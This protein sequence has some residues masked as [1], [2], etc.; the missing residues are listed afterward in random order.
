MEDI[1][2][3]GKAVLIVAGAALS[4]LCFLSAGYDMGYDSAVKDSTKTEEP[5]FCG[6]LAE[7]YSNTNLQAAKTNDL[8]EK[9]KMFHVRDTAKSTLKVICP[10]LALELK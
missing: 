3:A 1:K 9:E 6:K 4:S 2:V 5:Y 10:S 8:V 7:H